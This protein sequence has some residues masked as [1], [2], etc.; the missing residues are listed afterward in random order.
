MNECHEKQ[1]SI[2][3]CKIVLWCVEIFATGKMCANGILSTKKKGALSVRFSKRVEHLDYKFV[4]YRFSS[5]FLC[6]FSF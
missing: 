4:G 6:V 3:T 2:C 5:V 1:A